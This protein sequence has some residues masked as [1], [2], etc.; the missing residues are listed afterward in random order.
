MDH[1]AILS[2]LTLTP[3]AEVTVAMA[4]TKSAQPDKAAKSSKD[5]QVKPLSSVKQGA[6][7]KPSQTPKIKSKEMAKQ[8]A[9]KADKAGKGEK[10]S[11]K[12]KREP[13]PVPSSESESD[14]EDEEEEEEVEDDGAS[15]VSSD[16]SEAE[17]PAPTAATKT[18]GVKPNG[19]AKAAPQVEQ[20]SSDSSASSD[21]E[22]EEDDEDEDDDET[23]PTAPK[24]APAAAAKAAVASAN[25]KEES[26]SEGDSEEDSSDEESVEEESGTV[27]A[28][29]LN[30]K[31]EKVASKEVR[32]PLTS[33]K[34]IINEL[35]LNCIGLR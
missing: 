28:K 35:S 6:V 25:A 21:E 15:S 26:E 14:S 20:E 24:S 9:V 34:P 23:K 4:K 17:V 11:K 16:E 27:D 33:S 13:T 31:L 8:V 30:G 10:K 2:Q 22:D 5:A 29:A 3:V 12:P 32:T 18:N 1:H 19:V 7:S